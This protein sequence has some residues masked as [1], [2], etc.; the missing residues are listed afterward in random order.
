M[1][2][3]LWIEEDE[4]ASGIELQVYISTVQVYIQVLFSFPVLD[5]SKYKSYNS[6]KTWPRLG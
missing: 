3:L 1:L 2:T 6:E 5:K 4:L